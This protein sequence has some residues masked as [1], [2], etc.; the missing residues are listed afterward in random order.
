MSWNWIRNIS[1][2]PYS[3]EVPKKDWAVTTKPLPIG[4]NSCRKTISSTATSTIISGKWVIQDLADL[5]PKF[6][7]TF[8][9]Q[10]NAPRFPV[11]TSWTMIIRRWLKS[12]I[13]YSCSTTARQTAVLS[14][15]PQKWSTPV[16]DSSV[17]VW[18][19]KAKRPIMIRTYSS[20]CWK[21]LQPCRTLNTE[22]T[23]SKI[24]PCVWL[25]TTSVPLRSLSQTVS[26]L[27]TL[28]QVMWS[29]VSS[30]VPSVM[31]IHS[32]DR[33]KHSCTSCFLCW[34][35]IWVRLIRN[36]LHKRHWLKR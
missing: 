32:S 31:A 17:F 30:A 24:S 12:G 6:I 11:A 25:P 19:S 3:K 7:S 21:R 5:V 10:K 4:N 34:L 1:T 27:P 36:W 22:K 28:K 35:R 9:R 33:S 18:H 2:Q 8:V 20:Q 29:V 15:F 16:W 14:R 26:Y 13:S 23:R